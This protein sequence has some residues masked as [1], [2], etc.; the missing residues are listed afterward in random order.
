MA[1]MQ[2]FFRPF[3]RSP[4]R[5]AT[6]GAPPSDTDA[7][8]SAGVRLRVKF[9]AGVKRGRNG[10]VLAGPDDLSGPAG[11][12]QVLFDAAMVSAPGAILRGCPG[13]DQRYHLHG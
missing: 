6:A 12:G 8:A 13:F 11:N 3:Q 2:A 7:P 4:L 5:P 9:G 1:A 10:K